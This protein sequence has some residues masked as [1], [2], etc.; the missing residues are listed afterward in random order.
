[1]GI[2]DQVLMFAQETCISGNVVRQRRERVMAREAAPKKM[3]G[4]NLQR[5]SARNWAAA[6]GGDSVLV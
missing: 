2:D 6:E 1:M 3:A 4:S 5:A